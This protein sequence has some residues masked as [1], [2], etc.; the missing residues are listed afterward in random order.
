MEGVIFAL[1]MG[2]DLLESLS[3]GKGR[4]VDAPLVVSGG[5]SEHP[6]WLQLQADI[7]NRPLQV[8]ESPQASA[9]GA[10]LLAGLGTGVY[11][12]LEEA[13]PAAG[14][15]AAYSRQMSF[16]RPNPVRANRYATAFRD[17]STWANQTADR[18]RVVGTVY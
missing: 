1:R 5:A 17:W 11:Y 4:G 13:L 2:L 3:N 6:L 9:R 16:L 14:N 18:Y 10:A 7:F 15:S 12:S 8:F